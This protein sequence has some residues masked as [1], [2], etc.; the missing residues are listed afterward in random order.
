MQ[1]PKCKGSKWVTG[2]L[3][4]GFRPA[5][6]QCPDCNG[7]GEVD[8]RHLDW[9]K[10]GQAL[11]EYR[12]TPYRNLRE[13]AAILDIDLV[14]YS[15]M[16]RGLEDPEPA[17]RALWEVSGAAEEE[18]KREWLNRLILEQEASDDNATE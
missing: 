16:E 3:E 7:T 11:R 6:M 15:R 18:A 12:M 10:R 8:D 17:E 1:C 5:S 13:V 9:L 2:Y 14:A 4:P